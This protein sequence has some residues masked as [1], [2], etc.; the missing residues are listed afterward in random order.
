MED[1]IEIISLLDDKDKK[2]LSEFVHILI[3]RKKYD[4]LRKEIDARRAEIKNGEVLS[5]EELWADR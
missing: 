4:K 2:K 3:C 5:H 1:F